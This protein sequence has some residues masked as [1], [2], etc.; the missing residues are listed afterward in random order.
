MS[1]LLWKLDHRQLWRLMEQS[2]QASASGPSVK[3]KIVL[4]RPV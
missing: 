2:K 3:S 1:D 4:G